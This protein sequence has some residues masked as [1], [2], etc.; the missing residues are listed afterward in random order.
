MKKERENVLQS[1]AAHGENGVAAVPLQ[2]LEVL[3]G[4]EIQL[5]LEDDPM[6]ED[7]PG[8]ELWRNHA[9]ADSWEELQA[10]E[11]SPCRA[12]SI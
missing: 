12:V 8:R 3:S 7:V 11:R 2:P 1:P 5:Q 4:A 6:E 9:G 10:I